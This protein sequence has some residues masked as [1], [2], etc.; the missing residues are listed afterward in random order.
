[1]EENPRSSAQN[2]I[3]FGLMTGAALVVF[4]LIL[5]ISGQ[6][7]N[8]TLGYLSF[9]LLIGGMVYGTLEYRKK[10]ANGFL[11]YGK[12]FT[13]CF[14]IGL[15]AGL[16]AAVYTFVFAQFIFPGYGNMILEKAREGMLTSGREMSEE[17][18]DTALEYTRKFTTPV[19]MAIWGTVTYALFSAIF[20]LIIAIF[21]K[22]EDP[23]LK[24]TE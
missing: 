14:L 22:K 6:L 23:A 3:I 8:K 4:S 17:Q 15:F 7:M 10:Y 1:M 18:I 9:V 16:V 13:S 24:I 20:A 12:A 11:S 5:Y 19:M 2:G 21:L